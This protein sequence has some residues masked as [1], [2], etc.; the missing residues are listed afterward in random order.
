MGAERDI[1]RKKCFHMKSRGHRATIT[2]SRGAEERI[3]EGIKLALHLQEVHA[4][5]A[6]A[7]AASVAE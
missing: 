7:S 3:S 2:C 1:E 6:S 5:K 4:S